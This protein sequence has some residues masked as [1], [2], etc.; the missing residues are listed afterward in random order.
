MLN[1]NFGSGFIKNGKNDKVMTPPKIAKKIID[2]Y[3]V[4]GVVLDPCKG[5]GAFY[6]NYPLH[7][8]KDFCEI[9]QNKDFFEY[10]KPVDWIITN[11]P[12]SIFDEFLKHSQNIAD[13]IVYLIPMSKAFSSL[14]RIKNLLKYGNIYSIHILGAS[15][16][17]FPFGFPACSLYVKRNYK[18]KTKILML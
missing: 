7:C 9:D 15:Q 4:S 3:N 5:E 8:A 16:C 1:K 2:L 6:D 17:G 14:K 10:N 11:P 12:Y 13:N 18:G